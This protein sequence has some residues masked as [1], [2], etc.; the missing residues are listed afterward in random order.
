MFRF[1]VTVFIELLGTVFILLYLPLRPPALMPDDVP[2]A[3]DPNTVVSEVLKFYEVRPSNKMFAFP[4]KVTEPDGE[5]GV[6]ICD[7]PAVMISYINTIPDP[8]DPNDPN[9]PFDGVSVVHSY[10]CG[11]RPGTTQR[12]A[13][14]GFTF[15]DTPV[16]DPNGYIYLPES[17]MRTVL[18]DI[19]RINRKPVLSL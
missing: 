9:D 7:D 11:F 6:L 12:V 19:K 18:V 14:L 17:D 16:P 2:F 5:F 3:Y 10:A 1:L 15:T 4:M 8:L 13:K